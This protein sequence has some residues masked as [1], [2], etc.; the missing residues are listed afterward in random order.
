MVMYHGNCPDG[1][2][3]AL[4][5][6]AHFG[7]A[8]EYIAMNHGE[9]LPEG[10]EDRSV[11]ML[12][13]S[14]PRVEIEAMRER[15]DLT[16]VDH[17]ATA[18]ERLAG[19]PQ[20]HF[21]M[22]HSGAFLSWRFFHPGI[23]VPELL[24]Y[25]EDRDLWRFAMPY[26][27]EVSAAL[28]AQGCTTDFRVLIPVL[29]EWRVDEGGIPKGAKRLLIAEGKSI[30]KCEAAI[31]DAQIVHAEPV[32]LCGEPAMMVNATAI[33]S[34]TASRLL[35]VHPVRLAGY[36]FYRAKDRAYQVGLRSTKDFDSSAVASHYGGGGHPQAS[37]FTCDAL[38]WRVAAAKEA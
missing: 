31:V 10:W 14:R 34:E 20:T 26:S 33:F 9:P 17:H 4:A 32:T 3:S 28:K 22:E 16:I 1:A 18:Q 8:A 21:D 15:C 12:D 5:A 38:P 23:E 6:H 19:I 24:R 35:E 2:G 27:K 36:W 37:G 11:F 30:I 7:D 25:I 29:A 13:Y